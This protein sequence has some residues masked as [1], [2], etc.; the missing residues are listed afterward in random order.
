ML[1]QRIK[2]PADAKSAKHAEYV[3][4][5]VVSINPSRHCAKFPA[6][7][8]ALVR[9]GILKHGACLWLRL[10]VI[11][12][13]VSVNAFSCSSMATPGCRRCTT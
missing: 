12:N 3:A 2:P 13:V 11:L 5:L 10:W 9:G 8:I 6:M 4:L 1:A 7:S